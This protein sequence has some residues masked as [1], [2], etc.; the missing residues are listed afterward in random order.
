MGA[1]YFVLFAK[2]GGWLEPL[3]LKPCKRDHCPDFSWHWFPTFVAILVMQSFA[4]L[5]SRMWS[6]LLLL[7]S[8]GCLLIHFAYIIY[9]RRNID[10]MLITRFHGWLLQAI[11]LTSMIAIHPICGCSLLVLRVQGEIRDLVVVVVGD[12]LLEFLLPGDSRI[13]SF[14][15]FSQ[16]TE[17]IFC[18]A[19]TL[20]NC[21]CYCF[22]G[23]F[24][25]N[26][27]VGCC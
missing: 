24:A 21:F 26:T 8:V 7:S 25:A 11:S 12:K 6:I 13:F 4:V 27:H 22:V 5:S 15:I 10:T 20:I 9:D 18:V 17:V 23:L 1:V 3:K 19:I 16:R 14:N 2:R